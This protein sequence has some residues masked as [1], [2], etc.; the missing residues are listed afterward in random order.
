MQNKNEWGRRKDQMLLS[1]W[2][3]AKLKGL[4]L[5]YVIL[6]TFCIARKIEILGIYLATEILQ[7]NTAA[8]S[9]PRKKLTLYSVQ[10]EL[11]TNNCCTYSL[12]IYN[13]NT[14]AK[15]VFSDLWP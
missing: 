15:P 12:Q 4:E 9:K 2:D 8:W 6:L 7:S 1:C 13:L 14:Y 3:F 11:Y 5:N 10:P